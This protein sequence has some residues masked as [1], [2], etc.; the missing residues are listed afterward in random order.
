MLAAGLSL[1]CADAVLNGR[2]GVAHVAVEPRFSPRD[3]AIFRSLK[4]FGLG[5]TTV[6]VALRRPNSETILAEETVTLPEDQPEILVT[7]SVAISGS[8]ELLVASLEMFSGQVRTFSGSVNV[9]A[10][11]TALPTSPPVLAAV[12]VGP[13]VGATRV[14][15]AP[16]DLALGVNGRMTFTATATDASGTPVTDPDFTTR[17]QWRVNDPLLGTIPPNG[18][19]FVAAGRTGLAIITV[20]TPN[21]LRDTVRITLANQLPL[22]RVR[23]ARQIEVVNTAATVAAVPVTG[24]DANGTIVPVA[25]LSYQSRTPGIASVNPTTGAITG[26]ARGQAVIVVRGQDQG[27]TTFFEDSLLAIVAEPNG[28][29]VLSGIDR[30]EYDRNADVTVGV[31]VDMRSATRRLGSTTID[32]DWN[33]GVLQYVS[34]ANGASGVTPTVNALL[35]GQGRLTLAM[36][37]VAGFG[38]RVELLRITFR[39]SATATQGQVALAARELSAADFA[40]LLAASIH[41]THPISIR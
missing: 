36:A 28:P 2:T 37:D 16:R 14:Q 31:F 21:L 32:V 11:L 9:V 26:A 7:L 15:I 24:F 10:R 1:S 4:T 5:V 35:T 17:V 19:E 34:H 20:L 30:F 3:A 39:M 6:H 41:V 12:W 29:V 40:D 33:P 22:N 25:L 8:E 27:A 13:G 18:G 23:F 38:G